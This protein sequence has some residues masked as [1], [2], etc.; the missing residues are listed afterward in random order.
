MPY[1]TTV[2][3]YIFDAMTVQKWS[4]GQ[5]MSNAMCPTNGRVLQPTRI[6]WHRAFFVA[7]LYGTH[8]SGAAKRVLKK[9]RSGLA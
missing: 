1:C 7:P 3:S 8:E 5:R 6:G 4:N 2:W 9:S